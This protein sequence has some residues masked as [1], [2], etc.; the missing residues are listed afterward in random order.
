MSAPKRAPALRVMKFGGTSVAGAERMRSVIALCADALRETRVCLVASAM[1]GVTNELFA[2]L[3]GVRAEPLAP[4][5]L[6]ARARELA[7]AFRQRHERVLT[8][9]SAELEPAALADA[10]SAISALADELERLLQGVALLGET[11]PST[12]ARV[13]SF[14]ER[15]SCALLHALA[16][17]RGLAPL[18]LDP[19]E[20][21]FASGDRLEAVPDLARTRE[22]CADLRGKGANFSILP[23][24][25]AGDGKGGTSLLGRGGSDWSAAIAAHALDAELCEIWTDVEAVYSADPRVVDGAR[26]IAEMSFEEAMELSYFGAKVLHPKTIQPA[27]E[28]GIPVRVRSSFAPQNPGTLVSAQAA[29]DVHGVRALSLLTSVTL[30]ELSGAGLVGVPGIASRAFAALAEANVSV[31]LISQASSECGISVCVTAKDGD[32]SAAALERAFALEIKLAQIDPIEQRTG[33]SIVSVVG[34]GLRSRVGAAGTFFDAL[35]EVGVNVIAIAQSASER[36][37][38]AVVPEPD[39][40]RALKHTH[41]RLF[42]TPE[43]LELYL[44]GTGGVGRALLDQIAAQRARLR[45]RGVE[46]RVCGLA[47]SK[48]LALAR[49]GLE[50]AQA[51]ETLLAGDTGNKSVA[52]GASD[53]A[54][55]LAHVASE[56]PVTPVF[57][58]CTA[59]GALAHDYPAL[60]TGGLHVVA[61]NKHANAASLAEWR[62][63][64][65]AARAK[66]RRFLY[67]TNVGAGLPVLGT[68]AALIHAGDRVLAIEGVLSGSLSYI[69]GRLEEGAKFSEAVREA[70]ERGFTEPDPR[71]DLSGRDVARKVL[72]L[73]REIGL[74]LE[75]GDVR[76]EGLLPASFDATGSVERFLLRLPEL[77]AFFAARTA[78]LAARGGVLRFVG[79]VR[80]GGDE[81]D[82]ASAGL[83][84]V[85]RE[86]A[87]HAIRGG[88]NALSFL[89]EHYSPRPMVVRGYGAGAQV[90]AAG[91]LADILSLARWRRA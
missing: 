52:F 41:Q 57:V 78:E 13:T 7:Q 40:P 70:L 77:D 24:F 79:R 53:V 64:R 61:A 60:L 43:V 87:L 67:E 88:E 91:V 66:R 76:V 27:R 20:R 17:S 84:A 69:C 86:H 49:G 30:I 25:F 80:V 90:T 45:E 44:Y 31:I 21:V 3:E 37:I 63:L 10:R 58:D 62:A 89:T 33:L 9:L 35:A 47:N 65:E 16:R 38:S 32:R 4:D 75:P 2:A 1:S 55:V 34:D 14:G 50:P 22:R 18:L 68:L 23:G 82:G 26:P 11:P 83:V 72:I 8:E 73:A 5:R 6:H 46:L 42:E 71:E 74:A 36:S 12:V 54:R 48:T 51:R 39:G 81:H 19:C 59:S 29:P 56:R 85:D 28:L 15:A